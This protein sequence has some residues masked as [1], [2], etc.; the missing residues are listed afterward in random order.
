MKIVGGSFDFPLLIGKGYV[1]IRLITFKPVLPKS[2]I[3][4]IY[5]LPI[6]VTTLLFVNDQ[7]AA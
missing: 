7:T 2:N 1:G 5:Q 6:L 4:K 3:I